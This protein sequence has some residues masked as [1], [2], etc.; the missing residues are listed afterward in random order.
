[1]E[2]IANKHPNEYSTF[3]FP[4]IIS[5]NITERKQYL[6]KMLLVNKY[7]KKLQNWQE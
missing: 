6:N 7:L 1:M 2:E 5:P 3:L 4:I